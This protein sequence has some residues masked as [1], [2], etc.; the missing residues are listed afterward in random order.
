MVRESPRHVYD[1]IDY[2]HST[3]HTASHS[4]A[5]SITQHSTQHHT[6]HGITAH[7][8]ASH[9]TQHSTQHSITQH[10]AQHTAQHHTAQ[11]TVPI[12]YHSWRTYLFQNSD[13]YYNALHILCKLLVASPK[14]NTIPFTPLLP[15]SACYLLYPVR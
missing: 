5:H 12:K 8:T 7:S 10:T 2:E 1:V 6:A 11:H 15:C 14:S 9:I 4:T 3:Q 13:N